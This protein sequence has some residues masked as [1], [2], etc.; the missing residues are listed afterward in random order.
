MGTEIFLISTSLFTGGAER[1]AIWLANALS[2]SGYKVN[3]LILK[4]GDELSHL[5]NKDIN[6]LR[7]QIYSSASKIFFKY[8]RLARLALKTILRIRK[9]INNSNA[10]NKVIISFMFHS[11]VFGYLSNILQKNTKLIYSVRSDRLGKRSSKKSLL[12]HTIFK[13]ISY[14]ADHLVFNSRNGLNQFKKELNKNLNLH[15]IQNGLLSIEKKEDDFISQK[16]LDFLKDS[17]N[18]Y[19]VSARID[20]LNN[21]ENLIRAFEKLKNDNVDFK[22][23]IFGRGVEKEKIHAKIDEL[24]LGSSI[25]LIGN[26]NNAASYYHFFDLLIHP[27]FHAGFSNS[28]AEAIQSEINVVI[29][30]IGDTADLFDESGLILKNFDHN[31]I[32]ESIKYFN[33]MTFQE[34]QNNVLLSKTNLINLLDN[35]EA[36]KKWKLLIE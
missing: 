33:R 16:I 5:V 13:F 6:I 19:A 8:L 27:A 23:V 12:R 25:Y 4:K 35:N 3:L 9:I 31:A 36:I 26:V 22:C 30:R 2:K 11:Y 29:G 14:K 1:Q 15:F 7:F 32:Y 21:F 18:K 34:K 24:N 20:P 17:K 28:V 10:Q